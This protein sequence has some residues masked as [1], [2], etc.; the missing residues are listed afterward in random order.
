LTAYGDEAETSSRRLA[1][2][3]LGHFRDHLVAS[4][5][6]FDLALDESRLVY[7]G[8]SR[9]DAAFIPRVGLEKTTEAELAAGVTLGLVSIS[10]ASPHEPVKGALRSGVFA[11]HMTMRTD[12]SDGKADLI[13]ASGDVATSA[14]GRLLSPPEPAAQAEAKAKDV[15][16]GK[17]GDVTVSV[18]LVHVCFAKDDPP[19]TPNGACHHVCLGV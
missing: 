13:D 14:P 3:L 18:G 1:G 19:G 16:V 4:A 9:A 11:I 12:G 7:G 6:E 10:A 15:V 2:Q 17:V 5:H 8:S